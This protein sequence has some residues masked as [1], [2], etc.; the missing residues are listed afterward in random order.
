MGSLRLLHTSPLPGTLLLCQLAPAYDEAADMLI[1]QV[2]RIH[3]KAEE[4][5]KPCVKISSESLS[6]V[7][8]PSGFFMVAH[9]GTGNMKLALNGALTI[10]RSTL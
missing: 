7:I 3:H 8:G 9:I 10:E 1:R 4:F 5:T 2:Q 6:S